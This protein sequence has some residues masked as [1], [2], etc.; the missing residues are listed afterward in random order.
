[1]TLSDKKIELFDVVGELPT[2]NYPEEDVKEFIK[3]DTEF[4]DINEFLIGFQLSD[5]VVTAI[6]LMFKNRT[7][8]L[9]GVD[10]K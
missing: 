7:E 5:V 8:K 3:K 6:N 2:Y 1:M 10:L 9:A 4:L